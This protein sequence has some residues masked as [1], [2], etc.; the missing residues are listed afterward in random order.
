M[1]EHGTVARPYAQAV[2]ELARADGQLADWSRFLNLAAV[3][4][5]VP[6]VNRMLFT[7]GAD[8]GKLGATIAGLC[9]EQL[10]NP[11]LLAGEHS[12]GGNFL[13]LLVEKQRLG[14]LP[15][16]TA[17]FEVLKAEEE[18]V[19]EVT[20]TTATPVS[21]EQQARI[22]DSLKKRFG[23]QI[24]LSVHQDAQLIGGARLQVGDRVIDGSVRTGLDKLATAL[25]V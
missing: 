25:R 14:A 19:L 12:A 5:A 9:R 6:E 20:L 15:D 17:R 16:I 8:L 21:A 2:F 13:R 11:A 3:L 18:N 24:R 22:E 10:G 1:A 7:P 23:R 4:V